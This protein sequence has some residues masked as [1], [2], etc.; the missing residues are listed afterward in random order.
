M[1]EV[2]LDRMKKFKYIWGTVLTIAVLLCMNN[3]AHAIPCGFGGVSDSTAC[4]DGVLNN[5]YVSIPHTVNTENFFG[6]DDWIYLEKYDADTK[7]QETNIN[8]GWTVTPS[9]S[10]PDDNGDWSFFPTVWN[11]Y[12]DVMIVVKDGRQ[13][14]DIFFSGY[15][16]D[17]FIKPS[18]GTWDTG[19]SNLSHLTLYAR[20]AGTSVP[21]ASI[22]FLLGP[23]LIGLGIFSRRKTRK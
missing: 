18:S 4:Q 20:G 21:D 14:G 1:K 11:T 16:L 15:K 6:F 3:A 7:T 19:G 22:M 5:D 8:V 17:N 9:A 2:A 13:E 12:Q 23:S 10:W